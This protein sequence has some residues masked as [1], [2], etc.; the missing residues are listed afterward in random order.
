MSLNLVQDCPSAWSNVQL[1]HTSPSQLN[2]P[3][4]RWI[5]Q[6]VLHTPEERRAQ[7][8]NL[9]MMGGSA[10]NHALDM[11]YAGQGAEM[12]RGEEVQMAAS[13]DQA[14]EAAQKL[15]RDTVV[16][17]DDAVRRDKYADE[18]EAVVVNAMEQI[19]AFDS[20]VVSLEK[21]AH[22][23]PSW[24]PVPITG[25][26]D[27]ILEN[28]II[29]ELKTK[30]PHQATLKSGEKT[31]RTSSNPSA[32]INNWT[33]QATVYHAAFGGPVYIVSANS[34]NARKYALNTFEMDAAEANLMARLLERH[35]ALLDLE[36][37][38]DREQG[39]QQLLRRHPAD[40]DDIY[41]N[42]D[43]DVLGDAKRR[44]DEAINAWINT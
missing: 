35:E 18:I 27:F 15:L 30:W 39:L 9:R 20:P 19:D 23:H 2:Q 42:E 5:Y 36:K 14:V 44:W 32:P 7:N 10:V 29:I 16:W 3:M 33:R 43:P 13:V 17:D 31:W 26:A 24:A 6:Y 8:P 41:W 37:A 40:F 22:W 4:S 38:D 1:D 25:Y 12:G 28:G 11:I 34:L 21:Y